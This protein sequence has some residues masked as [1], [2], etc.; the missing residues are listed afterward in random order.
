MTHLRKWCWFAGAVFVV[1]F[2]LGVA[3]TRGVLPLWTFGV[4]N[5]PFGVLH[6]WFES[7]WVGT[8]YEL[9][10]RPVNE[11]WSFVTFFTMVFFQAWLYYGIVSLRRRAS[12]AGASPSV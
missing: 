3:T 5:C 9:Y 2:A 10:G 1:D 12:G 4:V 11:T 7:L 6:A 8:R